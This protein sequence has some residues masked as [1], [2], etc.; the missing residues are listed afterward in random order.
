MTFAAKTHRF[1]QF[2]ASMPLPERRLSYTLVTSADWGEPMV[3]VIIRSACVG[4][5]AVV[6]S[7]VVGLP[8]VAYLASRGVQSNEG[9]EVG[10][11][12]VVS[13]HDWPVTFTL[14]PVA[15]FAIGFFIGFRYF[16]RRLRGSDPAGS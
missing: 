15:V 8:L 9:A 1:D 3:T 2:G 11:D 5:A 12:F 10:W 7:F 6:V 4:I 16:S 13:A 14:T